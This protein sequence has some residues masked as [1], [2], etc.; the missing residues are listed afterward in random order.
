MPV[1]WEIYKHTVKLTVSWESEL[2][3]SFME[4]S[5]KSSSTVKKRK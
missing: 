1:P 3:N 4:M 5:P 2:G